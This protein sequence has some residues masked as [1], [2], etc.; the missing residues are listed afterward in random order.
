LNPKTILHL[1]KK[2]YDIKL[3]LVNYLLRKITKKKVTHK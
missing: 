3:I 2:K 1:S